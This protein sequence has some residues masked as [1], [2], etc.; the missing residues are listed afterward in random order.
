MVF[1]NNRD[2]PCE[3]ENRRSALD[4]VLSPLVDSG[5]FSEKQ[6]Q[7]MLQAYTNQLQ[8]LF[9]QTAPGLY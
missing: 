2:I 9:K 8:D 1:V 3:I 4:T 6:R 7:A 5:T